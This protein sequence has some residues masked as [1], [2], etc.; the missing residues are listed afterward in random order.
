LETAEREL[1]LAALR[2][3]RKRIPKDWHVAARILERAFKEDFGPP[4]NQ[5]SLSGTELAHKAAQE[6]SERANE[7]STVEP[8]PLVN[9]SESSQAPEAVSASL[10]IPLAGAFWQS[11]LFGSPDSFVSGPDATNS[12]GLIAERLAVSIAQG[13]TLPSMRAGQLRRLLRE[14]FGP[15]EAE[16]VMAALWR[17]APAS[18]GAPLPAPDQSQLPSG[19][20]GEE[21]RNQPRWVRVLNDPDRGEREWL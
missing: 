1:S 19:P 2:E 18:P 10:P 8:Q 12:L 21:G 3:E 11:L 5:P 4:R 20:R 6:S 9:A 14:R 15:Q 13:E 17:A 7:T 16:Q